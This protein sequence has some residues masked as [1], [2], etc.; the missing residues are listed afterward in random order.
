MIKY[1][2]TIKDFN[3]LVG[4]PL[5]RYRQKYKHLEKLRNLFF[6][7]VGNTPDLERFIDFYKWF[8]SAMTEMINEL[9]HS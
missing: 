2:A 7:K 9:I 5:N 8:D 4:Q 3:L 1:F 6:E